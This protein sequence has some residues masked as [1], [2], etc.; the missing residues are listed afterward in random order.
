MAY[1]SLYD[2]YGRRKRRRSTYVPRRISR[3][4][5]RG[6]YLGQLGRGVLVGGGGALGAGLAAPGGPM[7][8]LGA[9]AGST[10]G[11]A[12]AD[13]LGLGAYTIK[14]NSLVM[15]EG[16]QIA[17]F[18]DLSDAVII[19]HR[20]YIQDIV[21]PATP[22]LF[23]NNVFTLNPG[24]SASFPW[25][26]SIAGSFD[27]YMWLGIIYEFRSTSA[28]VGSTSTLGMGTVIMATDYDAHDALASSK[29]QMENMQYTTSAKPSD[30]FAHVIEC[31]PSVTVQPHLYVRHSQLASHEDARFYDHGVLQVATQGL[32]TGSTGTIG[33]LWCSYQIAFFKP[34]LDITGFLRSDHYNLSGAAPQATTSAYWGVGA[35]PVVTSTIGT[36]VSGNVLTFPASAIL[37]GQCF[38]LSYA[39]LGDST[40]L[41]TILAVT[42][43][44]CTVSILDQQSSSTTTRQWMNIK[45]IATIG[46]MTLT[47]T[48][49]TLPTNPTAVNITITQIDPVVFPLIA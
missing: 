48:A 8:I 23:T 44:G 37:P 11:G 7:S 25:L 14:S 32:P 1:P 3:V 38:W 2:R 6:S 15:P 30:S 35:T 24:L 33:E 34:Q 41:G 26:S 36:S 12:I 10:A 43:A 17:S 22:G 29:L 49:G 42:G 19:K 47:I 9:A 46:A 13:A 39:V 45:V 31:D 27:S 5:G 18:G 28:D 40:A 21:V 20:E 4:N 16:A